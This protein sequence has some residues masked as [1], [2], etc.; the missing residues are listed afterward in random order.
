MTQLA[1]DFDATIPVDVSVSGCSDEKVIAD[2]EDKTWWI[3][4]G[5]QKEQ[6][7]L[8]LCAR[9]GILPGIA[10]SSGPRFYPEYT[11]QSRYLDLKTVETPF[12]LAQKHYGVDSNFAV[13]LNKPDVLDC[14][15]KYPKCQLVFWIQWASEIKYGVE[16]ETRHEIRFLPYERMRELVSHAP[17]H[18]YQKRIDDNKGNAKESYILDLRDM[19]LTWRGP[20]RY[21]GK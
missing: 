5:N 14:T 7:F 6:D 9:E 16:V 13:S 1:F 21:E 18:V 12:F 15:Y 17:V 2:T 4:W 11:Y 3:G 8:S 10:A 20:T 19:E